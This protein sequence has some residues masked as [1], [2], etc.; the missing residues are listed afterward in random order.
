MSGLELK[1]HPPFVLILFGV[2]AWF[3]SNEVPAPVKI[4]ESVTTFLA[5]IL[6]VVGLAVIISA[7]LEFY[8]A[9]TTINPTQPSNTSSLVTGGIYR[10]T[11]NP[12][13]LALFLFLTGWVMHLGNII[14]MVVPFIFIAYISRFQIHP[15]EQILL[16]K[17]GEVYSSYYNEVKRWI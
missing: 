13:Y 12:M 15:E 6:G 7:M 16:S 11:R 4:A 1:I 10:F 2:L 3:I 17:F 9:K 5:I 8:R 14:G